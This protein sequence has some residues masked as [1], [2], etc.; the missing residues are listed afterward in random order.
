MESVVEDIKNERQ[1]EGS[2]A[3]SECCKNLLGWNVFANSRGV[4]QPYGVFSI[5]RQHE[6]NIDSEAINKTINN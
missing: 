3:N 1:N 6:D 4:N 2:P 5:R